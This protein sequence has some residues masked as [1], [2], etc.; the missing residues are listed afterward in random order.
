[1]ACL[2]GEHLRHLRRLGPHALAD[3]GPVLHASSETSVDVGVLIGEEPGG[4]LHVALLQHRAGFH[5]GVDLVAGAIEEAGVDEDDPLAGL[6]DG[7]RKVEGGATLLIHDPHLERVGLESE[8]RFDPAEQFDSPGDLVGAMHLGLHDVDRAGAAVTEAA[9]AEQVVLAR[10]RG[11]EAVQDRFEDRF[12]VHGDGVGGEV[13]ADVA[14]EHARP[15]LHHEFGAVRCGV[16]AIAVETAL[17]GLASLL[18]GGDKVALHQAEPVAVHHDL[19]VSV[20]G[21]D[22]I[23]TVHDRRHRRL[24]IDVG[25]PGGVVLADV[26]GAIDADVGMEAMLAKHNIGRVGRI[27]SEADELVRVGEAG[28]GVAERDLQ[29]TVDD[30]VAGGVGV[31][32]LAEWSVCVQ[33]CSTPRDDLGAPNRVVA[34]AGFSPAVVGDDVG[35]IERVIERTPAGVR[36]VEGVAGV[37]EWND[38]LG[39]SGARDLVVDIAGG[40]GDV[41]RSVLEVA[42]LP[43]EGEIVGLVVS[44]PVG[45]QVGVDLVLDLVTPGEQRGV[46]GAHLDEDG[47]QRCPELVGGD[48]GVGGQRR[49]DEVVEGLGDLEGATLHGAILRHVF[50]A[51]EGSLGHTA[52]KPGGNR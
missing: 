24:E 37:V 36:G 4:P 41:A 49:F 10:K 46:A 18:E 31:A 9:V 22:R 20:D 15:A 35:A 21:A 6:V 29:R 45:D 42:D 39:S 48:P 38:E 52:S 7:G 47:L 11:D 5:V 50:E 26:V 40:D 28:G 43:K 13:M 12:A 17:H 32:A 33:E 8:R 1:M 19:V 14:N 30:G 16:D 34:R 27:A 23:L 25:D 44:A 3:L 2:G 51:T